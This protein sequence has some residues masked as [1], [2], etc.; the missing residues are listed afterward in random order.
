MT[1]LLLVL[2]LTSLVNSAVLSGDFESA[3]MLLDTSIES[4]AV[5]QSSRT[6]TTLQPG[7]SV[8]FQLFVPQAGDAPTLGFN[9]VFGMSGNQNFGSS[10]TISGEDFQGNPLAIDRE[11]PIAAA[12]L[13][14]MPSFPTD[15]YIWYGNSSRPT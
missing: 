11:E 7:E 8:S 2:A 9:L 12:L 13:I 10:F 4:P 14:S 15:G 1:P 5:N 3:S 6:A